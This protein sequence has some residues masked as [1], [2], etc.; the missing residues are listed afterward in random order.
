M[1]D[2]IKK[3]TEISKTAQKKWKV[4]LLILNERGNKFI[5]EHYEKF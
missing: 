3:C 1:F 4:N 2:K 5:G